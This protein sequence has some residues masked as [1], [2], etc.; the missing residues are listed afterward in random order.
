VSDLVQ[1]IFYTPVVRLQSYVG[2]NY[3]SQCFCQPGAMPDHE[4]YNPEFNK[5][6][7]AAQINFL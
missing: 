3:N 5:F 4:F 1:I 7:Q 6:Q 2:A